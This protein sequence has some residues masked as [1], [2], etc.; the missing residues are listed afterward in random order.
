M[1]DDKYNSE[2][3]DTL[4]E[5]DE[6]DYDNAEHD[7]RNMPEFV[8][9]KNDAFRKIIISFQDENGVKEFE[10]LLQQR[11]TDKTKSLWFPPKE[12]H[13]TIDMWIDDN[14]SQ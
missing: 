11:I 5:S 13:N 14:E 12:K 8:N 2:Y 3:Q 4:F 7:W 6:T 1:T 10:K 9:E